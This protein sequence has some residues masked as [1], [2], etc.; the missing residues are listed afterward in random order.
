MTKPKAEA[1]KVTTKPRAVTLPRVHWL[2][3]PDIPI[4]ILE[5]GKV[6]VSVRRKEANKRYRNR[7]KE[8]KGNDE[9]PL[10]SGDVGSGIEHRDGGG[11]RPTEAPQAHGSATIASGGSTTDV[12]T[13]CD[14]SVPATDVPGPDASDSGT[15]GG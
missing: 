13:V 5:D 2:N 7:P 11:S 9:I 4:D 1:Q 8:D 10:R 3:R 6:A 12:P 15:T 14:A